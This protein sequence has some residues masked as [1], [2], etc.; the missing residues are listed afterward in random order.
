MPLKLIALLL[1]VQLFAYAFA[2]ALCWQSRTP[3]RRKLILL[4]L[5]I[6]N[7]LI[8]FTLLRLSSLGARLTAAWFVLM[9]YSL[10]GTA[11]AGVLLHLP[12]PAR[13]R[14]FLQ[15]HS[16]RIAPAFVVALF[17]LSF[18]NAYTP[19]VRHAEIRVNKTLDK[20]LRIGL[21][22]DLHLGSLVG[23]RQLDKLAAL[24]QQHKVDLIV[25][26]GDIMDDDTRAYSAEK[27]QPHLAKLR[28]PLGV[29]ATLGNHDLFGHQHDIA[30]AISDAG[31]TLLHDSLHRP[32]PQIQIIGRPDNLDSTRLPTHE[33]LRAAD[34]DKLLI[35]LDHRPDGIAEHSRLPIDIQVSGH[36]HNGQI[37][38]GNLIVRLLNELHYGYRAIGQGHYFVTSGYGFWGVPLRLGSQAEIWIIDVIGRNTP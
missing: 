13:V 16:R 9:L 25:L 4:C 2:R 32:H 37:F 19:T 18:Y 33:L 29:Y 1:A 21:A 17:A 7:A 23:A 26:P 20:P 27:M 11:A 28:A 6:T 10:F 38:P 12:A 8:A 35:L 3:H 36:V 15:R 5:L 31:I 34:S 14:A 24:M 22:A 30:Q